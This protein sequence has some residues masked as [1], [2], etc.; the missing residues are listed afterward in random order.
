MILK[1]ES[2]II[3]FQVHSRPFCLP[4]KQRMARKHSFDHGARPRRHTQKAPSASLPAIPLHRANPKRKAVQRFKNQREGR[5]RKKKGIGSGQRG[6]LTQC[7][8]SITNA[9]LSD[10]THTDKLGQAR[11]PN[12]HL[13]LYSSWMQL[14]ITSKFNLLVSVTACIE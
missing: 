8:I 9:A 13:V 3:K 6:I 11:A 14:E 4:T 12:V 5:G 1:K 10:I 7:N 2:A